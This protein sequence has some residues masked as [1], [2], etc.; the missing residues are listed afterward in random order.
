MNFEKPSIPVEN[1]LPLKIKT[2]EHVAASGESDVYKVEA[3]TPSGEEKLIALKQARKQEFVSDEEMAKS[4]KFYDFLKNFPEFGKFVPDTL[5]FKARIREGDQP[6]AFAIQHFLKGKTIDEMSDEELYK[7]PEVVSQLID[8]AK[9]AIKILQTTRREK[10]L[11]PDFGTA[12]SASTEAQRN[13]N[14]F[15]NSRYST[16]IYITDKPDAVGRR[17]F[18]I[19]TGVNADERID[20]FRQKVERQFMGRLREFNFKN[21]IKNLENMKSKS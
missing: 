1:H 11:K 16:N 13:G 7:D 18:F 15:G 4:K 3:E 12:F 6:Q 21:W 17:V 9:A 14:M 20:P 5:Y 10:G 2:D 8:F 19:D